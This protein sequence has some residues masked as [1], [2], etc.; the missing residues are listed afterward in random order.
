MKLPNIKI[1][2]VVPIGAACWFLGYCVNGFVTRPPLAPADVAAWVQAVGSIGAILGAI[3]LAYVQHR[4]TIERDYENDRERVRR[5]LQ[6]ILDEIEVMF[7]GFK[8]GVG[9]R[10]SGITEGTFFVG[11][12][13]VTDSRFRVYNAYVKE[14]GNLPD[15]A[16]RREIIG[17]HT[18][19]EVFV[20]AINFHNEKT[21]KYQQAQ[22]DNVSRQKRASISKI[23]SARRD[24]IFHSQRLRAS[25]VA[26]EI[27]TTDLM[28]NLKKSILYV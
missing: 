25:Y 28:G 11:Q 10:I 13:A 21:M 23:S 8:N 3:V 16:L 6:S 24:L 17:L 2:H 22:A 12:I 15:A 7:H 5:M 20:L 18:Q 27:S 14:I 9:N 26:I 4:K 19:F 1:W